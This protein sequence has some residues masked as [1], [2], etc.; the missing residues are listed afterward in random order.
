MAGSSDQ[1]LKSGKDNPKT[2]SGEVD[3]GR[4]KILGEPR[5]PETGCDGGRW[6]C[7]VRHWGEAG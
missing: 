5:Y 3:G 2:A 7:Q 4:A 6:R 1:T